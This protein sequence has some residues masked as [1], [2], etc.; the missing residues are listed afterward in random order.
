[1]KTKLTLSIVGIVN[2]IQSIGY[3]L[4]A[5]TA[6]EIMFN[7][8]KEAKEVAI[9]FQ[10]AITPAFLIVGLILF[11]SRKL[12][13]K[14]AKNLLLA[15]LIGYIP[16]FFAFYIIKSSPLT[17]IGIQDFAIDIVIFGLVLFTYIN[18]KS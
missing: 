6:S 8:G 13:V 2:I 12:P 16:L 5:K 15:L 7:T 11:L 18:P 17:N 3:A 10:Y 1:M 14:S 9:L 4:F